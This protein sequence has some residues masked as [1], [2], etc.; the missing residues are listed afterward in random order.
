MKNIIPAILT[1]DPG[2]LKNKLEQ[3][4]GLTDWV[5]IDIMDGKFVNNVSVNLQ[6]VAQIRPDFHIE[7]HLMVLNP[8][9]YFQDCERASVQRTIFHIEATSDVQS[10]LKKMAHFDFQKGLALN[11]ETSAENVNAYLDQIDVVLCMGVHI[12]FSGQ[13]FIPE[14]LEKVSHIK[15]RA[16]QIKIGV[17]GGIKL[18]NIQQITQAG[19]DYCAINSALFET[20]DIKKAFKELQ[21]KIQ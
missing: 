21:I 7:A 18:S 4:K 6:D 20:K 15:Q 3:I 10:I 13:E 16:P 2:D 12:G 5:H 1:N 14:I 9:N 17:D 11:P 8:E 19:S